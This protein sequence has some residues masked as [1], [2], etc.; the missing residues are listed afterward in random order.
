MEDNIVEDKIF[1]TS[2]I[3]FSFELDPVNITD[4]SGN[5]K[6]EGDDSLR[7]I[8]PIFRNSS[9]LITRNKLPIID[10]NEDKSI[11]FYSRDNQYSNNNN[12]PYQIHQ[13]HN[14]LHLFIDEYE[15][16]SLDNHTTGD[17]FNIL[18][19][20]TKIDNCKYLMQF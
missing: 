6:Y 5:I 2:G 18:I 16:N 19:D 7:N 15:N 3:I 14:L 4:I 12:H 1:D 10:G 13:Q 9:V 8:T 17:G 11:S 20:M